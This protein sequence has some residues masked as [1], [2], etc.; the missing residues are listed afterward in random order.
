MLLSVFEE[1]VDLKYNKEI[2]LF[3]NKFIDVLNKELFGEN[4]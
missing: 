4:K 2:S 3:T 1:K